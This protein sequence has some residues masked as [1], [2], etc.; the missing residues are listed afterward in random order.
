M[1]CN[2]TPRQCM[3]SVI[4][5]TRDASVHASASPEA[6]VR[7]LAA[8]VPGAISGIIRD[9][10][11]TGPRSDSDEGRDIARI[12][13]HAGCE[14]ADGNT[15]PEAM[16]A[17]LK[18]AREPRIFALQAGFV[19]ESGFYDELSD[20]TR[21]AIMRPARLL[22]RPASRLHRALPFLAPLAGVAAQK[23]ELARAGGSDFTSWARQI[24]RMQ[25]MRTRA[26]R[27]D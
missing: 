2:P 4:V 24:G 8:L 18:M 3:F 11:M 14:L 12:A 7:T 5:T 19:P 1:H 25:T 17:A 21:E 13:D 15:W 6:T 9:V 16:R 26:R 20:M 23:D 22:E 10:V 27:V